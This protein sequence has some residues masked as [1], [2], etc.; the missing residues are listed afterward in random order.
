MSCRHKINILSLIVLCLL[1]YLPG[2]TSLPVTDR[3][4]ARFAQA[5]KQMAQSQD[6]IDIQFQDS[7]RHKKPV[8]IYWLQ[9][10]SI[11]ACQMAVD[12]NN[13]ANNP[14]IWVYRVPSVIGA[15]IAVLIT[16]IWGCYFFNKRT[17]WLAAAIVASSLI[18]II[19]AHLATTDA[20]LLSTIVL[21]QATLG[22]IYLDYTTKHKNTKYYIAAAFWAAQGI[23]ILIK[24]PVTPAVSLL[25]IISLCIFDRNINWLKNIKPGTGILILIAIVSPW[26][27][28]VGRA[29]HWEFFTDSIT[30][31]L[32][33]KL[34][35]GQESH[36][37]LPGFYLLIFIATFWPGSLLTGLALK[38]TWSK[39][40]SDAASR[41]LLAG[42]IPVWLILEIIPTKLPH[43]IMPIYPALA[44]LT[45]DF[46]CSDNIKTQLQSLIA[47]TGFIL[48][49]V[50]GTGITIIP[51]II[52][53]IIN[54]SET[55]T[56]TSVICIC[57][58]IL[59]ILIS[60][61]LIWLNKPFISLTTAILSTIIITI[62][63]LQITL[64][65]MEKLWISKQLTEVILPEIKPGNDNSNTNAEPDIT[66]AAFDY[67][68]PSLVFMLGKDIK[69]E[70]L[71]PDTV[72]PLQSLITPIICIIPADSSERFLILIKTAGYNNY[73][74]LG[75]DISGY[76]YTKGTTQNLS[77]Y[78]IY[79]N[80]QENN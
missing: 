25:T 32:I 60:L 1:L 10:L 51:V 18:L 48:W 70:S 6:Y 71:S 26:I 19:E 52:M 40:N 14:P 31:D 76:N 24:G 15:S 46:I 29:T 61:C 5:T 69:L 12:E 11:K 35:S 74:K 68:E 49:A 72:N 65:N 27:I 36:G 78:K 80:E 63:T 42:I 3:D 21:S 22:T 45:A 54:S 39:R 30:G 17:S 75:D 37:L 33:P 53:K 58:G 28:A 9:T 64:P 23:G 57:T 44:L 50:V 66:I 59:L 20:A 41:F 13:P 2:L 8:G 77:L 79:A 4:E 7:P 47:R 38:N 16:Y 67:H 62:N 34:I 56:L 55:V 73:Q 43:Y